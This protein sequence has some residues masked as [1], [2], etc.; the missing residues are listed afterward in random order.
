MSVVKDRVALVAGATNDVG[1]AI[2]LGLGKGQAKVV[3]VDSDAGKVDALVSKMS[4]AGLQAE[5][6]VVDMTNSLDVKQAI[7]S[8]AEKF[9]A[10][11]ILVN[12]MDSGNGKGIAEASD[13]DWNTSLN[14]NLTPVYLFCKYVVP[15]MR[16]KK[17]GRII[18]MSDLNYLGM[19]GQA[20]YAA[21]KSGIFGLTRGLALELGKEGITV[22]SIVKGDIKESGV[23]MSEEDLAKAAGRMP[24]KRLG[25]ADDVAY[26]ACFFASDT[27]KYLTGQTLFVCGGKS[28]YSSMSV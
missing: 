13:E 22:N 1:E 11:D 21:A 3:V 16:E 27:S 5:G 4:D 26:A 18:N 17:Y 12:C 19:P 7:D 20:N 24:V 10:I 23:E 28:L 9:G 25:N 14:M 15:K 6:V 8:L 2:C